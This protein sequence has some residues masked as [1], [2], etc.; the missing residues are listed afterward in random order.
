MFNDKQMPNDLAAEE[1]RA[2][3]RF[4]SPSIHGLKNVRTRSMTRVHLNNGPAIDAE[5]F[6]WRDAIGS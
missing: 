5:G 4:E 1:I 3:L 2:M 6:R